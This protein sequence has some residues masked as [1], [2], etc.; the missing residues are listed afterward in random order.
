MNKD[1]LELSKFKDFT[2]DNLD[3]I[4][5]FSSKYPFDSCD[6]NIVNLFSWGHFLKCKWQIYKDRLII[7]NF[8][9]GFILFPVG[10]P[11]TPNGLKEISD[12]SVSIGLSGIFILAPENYILNNTD[13]EDH[14]ELMPDPCNSDYVYLAV[15]LAELNGKKLQKKKNLI[16]QFKR[17]YGEYRTEIFREEYFTLCKDLAYKWCKDHNDVCDEEKKRELN[18]LE[19]AMKNQSIL[20]LEGILI[21]CGSDVIAYAL[22]SE[23]NPDMATIHFEKFDFSYKGSAQLINQETAINLQ[24]KYKFINREQDL[25][26]EGLRKSKLSY[27][28]EM[29]IKTFQLLRKL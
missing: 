27:D 21:F 2:I 28:P 6:Y 18:V 5:N 10:N 14:F 1:K 3:I 26:M 22:F 12:M 4:K 17:A 29:Q 8:S 20:G 7:Y 15:K 19:R 25:C 23:Q 9:T 13:L 24:K 16:S 11:F